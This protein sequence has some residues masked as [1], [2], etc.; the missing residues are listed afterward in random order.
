MTAILGVNLGRGSVRLDQDGDTFTVWAT[1]D[2]IMAP[3]KRHNDL[4]GAMGDYYATIATL[5][6]TEKNGN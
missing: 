2:Y 1:G 6:N 5:T 4:S 3:V